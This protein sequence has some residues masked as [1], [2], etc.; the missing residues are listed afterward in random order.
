MSVFSPPFGEEVILILFTGTFLK[1]LISI[2]EKNQAAPRISSPGN[3][4]IPGNRTQNPSLHSASSLDLVTCCSRLQPT[5]KLRSGMYTT[6]ANF[7]A[8]S[9]DIPNQSVT[10][11]STLQAKH[12]SQPRTTDRS[13]C[14]IQNMVNAFHGLARVKHH[15]LFASTLI[16]STI[17]SFWPECQTRKSSNSI[18]VRAKWCRNTTTI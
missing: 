5:V 8:R 13:S 9:R 18:L 1:I 11:L 12:S 10:P 4:R 17:T 3:W 2:L 16:R 6:N 14:G 7:C 15:M